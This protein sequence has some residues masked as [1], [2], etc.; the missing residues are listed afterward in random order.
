[1]WF[2][3]LSI[4]GRGKDEEVLRPIRKL[5]C[6]GMGGSTVPH[7][8]GS[9]QALRKIGTA[10]RGWRQC[11]RN[12]STRHFEGFVTAH[13]ERIG[14]PL[15]GLGRTLQRGRGHAAGRGWQAPG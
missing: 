3:Q 8:T 9:G 6:C 11:F 1:M 10:T 2:S 13:H 12:G 7:S 15:A 5:G 4:K 14:V